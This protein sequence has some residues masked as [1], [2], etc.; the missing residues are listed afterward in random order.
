MKNI[1]TTIFGIVIAVL[2]ALWGIL[3]PELLG[4][5]IDWKVFIPA[6]VIVIV[7]IVQKDLGSWKTTTI[8]IISAALL[9]GASSY[10]SGGNH[11]TL[12]IGA[13]LT[14]IGGSLIKDVDK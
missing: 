8:G 6:G 5:G 10:Q 14:A 4:K 7:G 1:K 9:A 11:W 13:M 12:I 2:L 3:Q